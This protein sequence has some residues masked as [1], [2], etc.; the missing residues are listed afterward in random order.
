[1]RAMAEI[2]HPL[3]RSISRGARHKCPACG[4]SRLFWRYLKVIDRC[5]R[6]D[7]SL[8]QYP[9]DDGPAY[10]T[11]LLVGH[12][13]VAPLLLFPIVWESDPR[14]S[15]PIILTSM[16]VITLSL[17]PRV[18]GGWVGLMY[19]LGVNDRDSKLHTADAAD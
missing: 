2:V 17:L 14:W 18:K 4:E 16:A 3:M 15:L 10:L 8:A 12:L 9:A 1:M 5:E 11:I 6:C 19:A 7:H 13:I